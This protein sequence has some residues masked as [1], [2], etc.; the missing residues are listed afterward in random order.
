MKHAVPRLFALVSL[1]ALIATSIPPMANAQTAAQT[2][3]DTTYT[4]SANWLAEHSKDSSTTIV[5]VR[6]LD[7]YIQGH[8]PGAVNLPYP[9]LAQPNSDESQIGPWQTQMMELLGSTGISPGDTVVSCDD[10]GNLFAA[11][12]RS[13]LKYFGHE[14]AA[15]LDGGLLAWTQLGEPVTTETS[16]TGEAAGTDL[17]AGDDCRRRPRDRQRLGL[18]LLRRLRRAYVAE[19]C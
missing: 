13:V 3:T 5:D 11:R 6:P 4:V 12:M 19:R 7:A 2:P 16:Y 18:C 15:V 8:I 1:V 14:H 17:H 10:A 9:K